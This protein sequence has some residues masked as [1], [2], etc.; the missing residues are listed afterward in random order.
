MNTKQFLDEDKSKVDSINDADTFIAFKDV[1]KQVNAK[2]F[3]DKAKSKV[4]SLK[5]TKLSAAF[6]DALKQVNALN[7]SEEKITQALTNTGAA[8]E[9]LGNYEQALKYY[10]L[11]FKMKA[12]ALGLQPDD[13]DDDDDDDD[14]KVIQNDVSD[15]D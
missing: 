11:V 2:Q 13:D 12:V 5:D 14:E 1:L 6:D 8:Y 4:D 7:P 3:L 10:D 15:A 9:H